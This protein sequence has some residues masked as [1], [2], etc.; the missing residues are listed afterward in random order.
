MVRRAFF[1]F[2]YDNDVTRANVVRNSWVTRGKEA[3]GFI[4]KAEFEKLKIQGQK[5]IYDWIDNQLTGTSVTVVL[6]G[7]ETLNRKYVQYE[8]LE[9]YKRG[10]AIIGVQIGNIKNLSGLI[11]SSQSQ[12]TKIGKDDAG[13]DIWFSDVIEGFYN[14]SSDDGYSNLGTWIE[15]AANK[16]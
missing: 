10:K 6:I 7:A 3:A 4:D 13:K 8:I 1:S 12:Y 2:H 16:K 11:S 15:N 9:S 14:Y 5:A